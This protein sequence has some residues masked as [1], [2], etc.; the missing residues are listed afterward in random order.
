[1]GSA[2]T[3]I[4]SIPE[5]SDDGQG[6]T[7]SPAPVSGTCSTLPEHPATPDRN[8]SRSVLTKVSILEDKSSTYVLYKLEFDF[9]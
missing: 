1:M 3:G 6:S 5:P 2:S 4:A 8:A 7:V 9:Y